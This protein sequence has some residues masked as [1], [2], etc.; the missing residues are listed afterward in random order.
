MSGP[1][2]SA[3]PS[4]QFPRTSQTTLDRHRTVRFNDDGANPAPPVQ[5]QVL[6]SRIP[7]AAA[8]P[9]AAGCKSVAMSSAMGRKQPATSSV[10]RSQAKAAGSVNSSQSEVKVAAGNGS[11]SMTSST[12]LDGRSHVPPPPSGSSS[13]GFGSQQLPAAAVAGSSKFLSQHQQQRGRRIFEIEGTPS[14]LRRIADA[15]PLGDKKNMNKIANVAFIPSAHTISRS[16]SCPVFSRLCPRQA[17]GHASLFGNIPGYQ[18]TC[19]QPKKDSREPYLQQQQMHM[20]PS[21]CCFASSSCNSG[22]GRGR[23]ARRGAHLPAEVADY[24]D[25]QQEVVSLRAQNAALLNERNDLLVGRFASSS[26][27]SNNN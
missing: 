25:L 22:C 19:G 3:Q 7:A 15:T 12:Q 24:Y 23:T 1:F 13:L 6:R 11:Q 17:K 27:S 26:S 2:Y 10:L 21:P 5:P 14:S 18:G 8:E 4:A 16:G 9:S 20:L